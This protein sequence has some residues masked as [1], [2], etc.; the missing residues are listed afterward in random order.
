MAFDFAYSRVPNNPIWYKNTNTIPIGATY[1]INILNTL[2]Y[3]IVIVPLLD[4]CF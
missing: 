4:S 1:L 2:A 3:P